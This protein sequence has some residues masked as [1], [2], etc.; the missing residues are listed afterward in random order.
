MI[1]KK[2]IK[3]IEK[4][5]IV[6]VNT[7]ILH[8]KLSGAGICKTKYRLH[9]IYG[10]PR[11]RYIAHFTHKA[12]F[13]QSTSNSDVT[14]NLRTIK[15]LALHQVVVVI[16]PENSRSV[17]SDKALK[18]ATVNVERSHVSHL[19]YNTATHLFRGS[20]YTVTVA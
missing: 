17:S 16:A 15:S 2:G 8:V 3:I 7:H 19:G 13:T 1:A 18:V 6:D 20:V 5:A 9:I 14:L 11:T 4:N 10:I 12:L